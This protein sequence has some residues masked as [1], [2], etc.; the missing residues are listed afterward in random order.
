[1]GFKAMLLLLF[2]WFVSIFGSK[3]LSREEDLELEQELQRRTKGVLVTIQTSYGDIYDC[4]DFYQQP[5]FDNPLM[6]NH[7]YHPEMKPTFY[8]KGMRP[9]N[10]TSNFRPETFWIN[11]KGCPTG[12]VPI[13]QITKDDLIRAKLAAERYASNLNPQTAEE[14][15]VHFAVIHTPHNGVQEKY[16]GASMDAGLYNPTL[17]SYLQYTSSQIKIQNGHE[18]I[19]FGWTV[20]PEIYKDY[21][22]RFFLYTYANNKHCFNNFCG[23]FIHTRPDIPLDFVFN[24]FGAICEKTVATNLFAYKDPGSGDWV[25]QFEFVIIG[26]WPARFFTSLGSFASYVEWGGEA[27]SPPHI[28]SPEMGNGVPTTYNEGFCSA[29]CIKLKLVNVNRQIIDPMSLVTYG[30]INQ[31][32]QVIDRGY[33]KGDLGRGISYGGRGGYIGN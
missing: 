9:N 33:R 18:S 8:P 13:R 29:I 31:Y 4:V 19:I 22:T 15:G 12:T 11:G 20:H 14:H 17:N 5:A 16:Y 28:P 27:Y 7:S 26:M 3:I 2:L 6:K 23:L 30:D 32:Y 24:R 21:K 1:M 10:F 25:L